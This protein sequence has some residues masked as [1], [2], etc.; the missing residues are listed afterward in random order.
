MK[1]TTTNLLV[2]RYEFWDEKSQSTRASETY[3]TLDA[4][5]RGT[6]IPLLHTAK[7][8]MRSRIYHDL[9]EMDSGSR[10]PIQAASLAEQAHEAQ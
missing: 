10:A 1:T 5:L 6:G 8:V 9:L 7:A 4:I 3:A 2:Y